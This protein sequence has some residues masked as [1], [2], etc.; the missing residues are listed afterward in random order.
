MNPRKLVPMAVL[1]L[2]L[3]VSVPAHAQTLYDFKVPFDF[4]ANGRVFKAGDYML[5][6]NDEANV[7]TLESKNVKGPTVL[8]PVET[9]IASNQSLSDPVVVFDKYEGKL[10]V[11]ELMVPGEDGYLFLVT[12]AKHTH[13]VLSG[14]RRKG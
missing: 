13:Q 1:A 14:H 2:A 9:R 6:S 8:L 7:F 12:K 4:T 10:I 3:L 5:V 11:S